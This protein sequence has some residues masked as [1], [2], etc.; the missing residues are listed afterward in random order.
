LPIQRRPARH[1]VES[2]PRGD[3]H[4]P[5]LKAIIECNVYHHASSATTGLYFTDGYNFRVFA[6]WG[7]TG[8]GIY[9]FG[10]WIVIGTSVQSGDKLSIRIEHLPYSQYRACFHHNGQRIYEATRSWTFS[11]SVRHGPARCLLMTLA[12][13]DGRLPACSTSPAGSRSLQSSAQ[14]S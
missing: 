2:L 7:A 1:V 3:D 11:T 12:P 14:A 6:R 10:S 4:A 8:I 13:C 9:A 5:G